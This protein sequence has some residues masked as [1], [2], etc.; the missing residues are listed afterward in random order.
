MKYLMKNIQKVKKY[1]NKTMKLIDTHIHGGFGINF[2]TCTEEDFHTFARNI[3]LRGIVAFCPTLVGDNPPSLKARIELI[4]KVMQNQNK[5]EAKILGVHLEGTFLSPK[6]SGIQNAGMFLTP[7]VENFKKITGNAA[8]IIKIVTLAPE[9]DENSA[10]QEYLENLDIRTHAGH[11]TSDEL[12]KV[13]GTTHHF[14]AMEPLTHKKS[15]VALKGLLNDDIYSEIIG[16]SLHVND[17]MLKLFFKMK[18]KDKVILVSDALPI[19]H[20]NLKQIVFCGKNI[21]EGGKDKDGTLAGSSLFLDEIVQNLLNKN[22]LDEKDI[23]KAGFDN[24]IAHLN[25]DEETVANLSA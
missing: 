10:L 6:K 8:D 19:A 24:I 13:S 22:I 11:T 17:D 18:N 14:N 7:T 20:S 9:L 1:Y 21:F 3:I 5:D 15:N 23:E 4:K 2:N 12:Y 25:L 16:D